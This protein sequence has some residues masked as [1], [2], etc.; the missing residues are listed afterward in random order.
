MLNEV[1]SRVASCQSSERT[2]T[3]ESLTSEFILLF[4]LVFAVFSSCAYAFFLFPFYLN[5]T[6]AHDLS[7]AD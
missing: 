3:L 2:L 4:F 5:W 7:L 1:G 6:L